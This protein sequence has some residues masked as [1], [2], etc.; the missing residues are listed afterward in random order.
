MVVVDMI[1]NK[2]GPVFSASNCGLSNCTVD[3]VSV[4]PTGKFAVVSTHDQP[5]SMILIQNTLALEYSSR[6]CRYS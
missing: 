1:N 6:A 5:Q 2:V 3:W 4:S